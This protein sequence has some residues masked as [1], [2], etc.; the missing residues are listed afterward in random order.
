MIYLLYA[1][2]VLFVYKIVSIVATN[3]WKKKSLGT[4]GLVEIIAHRGSRLEG[5]PENTI[6]AFSDAVSAGTDVIEL[7]V[8]ITPD[9]KVV[10]HHDDNFSRMSGGVSD[11][12]VADVKHKD[13]PKIVPPD[14]Q[15]E[16]VS[17]FSKADT[18]VI[19]LFESVLA[20]VPG[21]TAI[22]IEFKQ[23]S[24]ELISEVKRIL[25]DNKRQDTVFWFSLDEKINKKL[26]KADSSIPTIV[27]IM[28][29][30]KILMLYYVGLLPFVEIEDAVFGVTTEAVSYHV[31]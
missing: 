12:R 10:V 23:D 2:V 31:S 6:A 4:K 25:Y 13:F 27:S 17:K 15:S 30:L 21:K 29:M 8:W 22:I 7:D 28:G 14:N 3:R 26:R 19:P 16:R 1:V 20:A 18:T 11:S 5:L 9:G 24:D